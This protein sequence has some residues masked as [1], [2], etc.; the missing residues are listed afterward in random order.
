MKICSMCK[1]NPKKIGQSYCS[2]C[3]SKYQKNRYKEKKEEILKY[4][5]SYIEKNKEVVYERNKKYKI[6][7]KKKYKQQ[8][9]NW[10]QKNSYI[11]NAI[12]RKRREQKRNSVPMWL[13]EDDFWIIKEAY[14]L[15]KL[16]SELFGIKFHVDH[17]IPIKGK[18]VCGLHSPNNLQVIPAQ[19]NLRKGNSFL[20][21]RSHKW[22][23]PTRKGV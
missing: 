1:T 5:K 7:N 16:R 12:N 8:I 2:P 20:T 4:Q 23:T 6:E 19:E 21:T 10:I 11:V 22:K 3:I 15:A 13:T 9:K 14:K 17:I 18:N